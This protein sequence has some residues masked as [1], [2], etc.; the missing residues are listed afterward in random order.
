MIFACLV[1]LAIAL[2]SYEIGIH[3]SDEA[4]G[5]IV[6]ALVACLV[7]GLL[8]LILLP[9]FLKVVVLLALLV[10]KLFLPSSVVRR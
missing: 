9:W 10:S 7:F 5:I 3:L 1:T 8:S 4:E 2:V 6:L